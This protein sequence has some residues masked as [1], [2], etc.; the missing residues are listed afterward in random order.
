MATSAPGNAKN[1][2]RY[3]QVGTLPS[4][5]ASGEAGE[6]LDHEP[7]TCFLVLSLLAIVLLPALAV[8]VFLLMRMQVQWWVSAFLAIAA[9]MMLGWTLLSKVNARERWFASGILLLT[10]AAVSLVC[11]FTAD[12]SPDGA[13]YHTEAVLALEHGVN[14][15]IDR[16]TGPMQ[17]WTN[18]Y[19]KLTW[20]FAAAVAKT[21]G[22]FTLGKSYTL[23]LVVS[24]WIYAWRWLRQ[25]GVRPGGALWMATAIAANP[26]AMS[27]AV[28]MYLDGAVASLVTMALLACTAIAFGR[29]RRLDTAVL[30]SAS[31]MLIAIK[32]TGT[33]YLAVMLTATSVFVLGRGG[34]WKQ[35]T[36]KLR[37]LGAAAACAVVIGLLVLGFNPYITNI[38]QGHHPMYPLAGPGKIDIMAHH[39]SPDVF[40]DVRR[41]RVQNL[42]T[43]LLSRSQPNLEAPVWKVP[44]TTSLG[45]I[46]SFA[47][48]DVH[49]GGW[50]VFFSG[51]FLVSVTMWV[52]GQ[53]WR[54]V[55]E[56]SFAAG[57]AMLTVL[58]TPYAWWARFAPQLALVPV[59]LL[60]PW[61]A[62]QNTGTL[63][64]TGKLATVL[65]S[66][67]VVDAAINAG[68]AMLA[69][70][71][72]TMRMHRVLTQAASE[73]GSG[74]YL[75]YPMPGAMPYHYEPFSGYRGIII[76]SAAER[77]PFPSNEKAYTFGVSW[78]PAK[79][80]RVGGCQATPSMR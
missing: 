73:C 50:G 62:N 36:K 8:A 67:V 74:T 2:N 16:F 17:M 59:F 22:R 6:L 76:E 15:V 27:Q 26:V 77:M 31:A 28:S 54:R 5:R 1:G 34:E 57:V 66:L 12:I 20:Y 37:P 60:V 24:C 9:V 21:T 14:P 49:L 19:P 41:N 52:W 80:I 79:L 61:M 11:G 32:F 7:V 25:T 23:L 40:T 56:A 13:T 18:H 68:C 4:N 69:S 48:P 63:R 78:A 51:V 58:A 10:F 35:R 71:I 75:A 39:I 33:A 65:C 29:A 72:P 45:E 53:A 47:A 55:P 30:A 46:R 3:I 70:V 44:F 38:E 42:A 43:S 64:R